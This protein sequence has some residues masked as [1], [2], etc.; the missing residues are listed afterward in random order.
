MKNEALLANGQQY[1]AMLKF[2]IW[3]YWKRALGQI[4]DVCI[5]SA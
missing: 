3:T 4:N 2:I 1:I 5:T